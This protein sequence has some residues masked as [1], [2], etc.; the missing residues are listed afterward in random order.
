MSPFQSFK[1][2]DFTGFLGIS[3]QF[4]E[5]KTEPQTWFLEDETVPEYGRCQAATLGKETLAD[6]VK[7]FSKAE[8]DRAGFDILSRN[9]DGTDKPQS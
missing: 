5:R 3:G 1:D 4:C 9:P 2:N 7:W 6:P 8:G